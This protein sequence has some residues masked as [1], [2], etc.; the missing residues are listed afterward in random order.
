MKHFSHNVNLAYKFYQ[1]KSIKD[2]KYK[3]AKQFAKK[4]E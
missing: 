4:E 2:K 1:I 3:I